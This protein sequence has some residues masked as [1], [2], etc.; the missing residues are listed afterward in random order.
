MYGGL[1]PGEMTPEE[2]ASEVAGILAQGFL[3][4]RKNG[5]FEAD[6]EAKA[7]SRKPVTS[8]ISNGCVRDNSAS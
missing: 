8:N 2:R 3:R 7:E 4:L 5:P 6:S 1:D